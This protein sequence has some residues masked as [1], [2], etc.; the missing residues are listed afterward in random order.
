VDVQDLARITKGSLSFDKDRIILTVPPCDASQKSGDETD[1][2]R[3]S[4]AFERAAIEASASIR[5]WA[6]C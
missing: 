6:E 5:E 4:R 3:F 2:S 1:K